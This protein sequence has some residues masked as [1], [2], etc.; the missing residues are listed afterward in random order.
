MSSDK[1]LTIF[2]RQMG[3]IVLI[4]LQIFFIIII[5]ISPY[6]P[7]WGIGPLKYFSEHTKSFEKCESLENVPVISQVTR[8][9]LKAAPSTVEDVYFV[10][11]LLLVVIN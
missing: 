5:T 1:Y 8:S 6:C 3:A 4:I 7:Q 11:S 2:S 9:R 10:A